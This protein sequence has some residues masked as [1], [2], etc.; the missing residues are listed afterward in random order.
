MTFTDMKLQFSPVSPVD[1]GIWIRLMTSFFLF[2]FNC[3]SAASRLTLDQW[4]KR[5]VH[6][7]LI[8][9]FCFN[10]K[11][12]ITGSQVTRLC[13]YDQSCPKLA[14]R[15]PNSSQQ[16]KKNNDQPS[17]H[18]GL[19]QLPSTFYAKMLIWEFSPSLKP[20]VFL[21]KVKTVYSYPSPSPSTW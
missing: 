16:K 4:G 3:Y 20:F 2:F 1:N 14:G 8:T 9:A 13:P 6:S 15:Q 7:I 5:F 12:K 19:N 10:F 21:L 17:A 11:L 18:W